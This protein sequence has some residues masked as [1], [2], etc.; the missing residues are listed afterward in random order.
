MT[1]LVAAEIGIHRRGEQPELQND[2][3]QHERKHAVHD[4]RS[5]VAR[6]RAFDGHGYTVLNSMPVA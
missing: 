6:E 3:H 1:R 5:L 2:E 4:G